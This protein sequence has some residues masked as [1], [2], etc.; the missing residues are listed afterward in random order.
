MKEWIEM[1]VM[2]WNE[3]NE[4]EWKLWIEMKGLINWT[5]AMN[6]LQ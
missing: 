2:N 5:N 3:S 1:R 6:E 4:L